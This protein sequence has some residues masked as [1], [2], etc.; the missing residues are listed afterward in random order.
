M[1]RQGL[2]PP[3]PCRAAA[4]VTPVC[5][6]GGWVSDIT[7]MYHYKCLWLSITWPSRLYLALSSLWSISSLS[8]LYS[9]SQTGAAEELKNHQTADYS[10][11]KENTRRGMGIIGLIRPTGSPNWMICQ[12]EDTN[13]QVWRSQHIRNWISQFYMDVCSLGS[14][15]SCLPCTQGTREFCYSFCKINGA[16]VSQWE[17]KLNEYWPMLDLGMK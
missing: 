4:V 16:L 17:N 1:D 7:D 10:W 15:S 5:R 2:P 14:Q 13:A 11:M 9:T 3:A 8:S 6:G 12:S